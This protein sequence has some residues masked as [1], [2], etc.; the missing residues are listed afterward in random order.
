M[1]IVRIG[2]KLYMA[3]AGESPSYI[4]I[5]EPPAIRWGI[6]VYYDQKGDGLPDRYRHKIQQ[7][8]LQGT[9]AGA[10]TTTMMMMSNRQELGNSS[11]DYNVD[12]SFIDT[13]HGMR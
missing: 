6:E 5:Y 9:I 8:H 4:C 1:I 3:N 11:S 13:A 10:P 2:R 12:L 7:L